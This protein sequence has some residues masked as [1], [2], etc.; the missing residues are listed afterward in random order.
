MV[1]AA[2]AVVIEMP[3]AV[4]ALAM[5]TVA[6]LPAPSHVPSAV[7]VATAVVAETPATMV[8]ETLVAVVA[9]VMA[10]A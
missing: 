4:V 1:A 8:A 6:S 10:A 3:S 5:A 9:L 2:A 7:A